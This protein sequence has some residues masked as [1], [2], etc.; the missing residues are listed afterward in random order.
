VYVLASARGV[1]R[2]ELIRRAEAL[3]LGAL[4]HYGKNAGMYIVDRDGVSYEIGLFGNVPL[5]PEIQ[6]FG[7]KHFAHLKMTDHPITLAP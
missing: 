6:E 5:T 4:A 7:R 2:P 1:S 3:L